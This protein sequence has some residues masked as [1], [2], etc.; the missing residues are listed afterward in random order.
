M[1]LFTSDFECNTL[2]TA[3]PFSQ[4]RK[5]V[6][7]AHKTDDQPT[8]TTYAES[9][10]TL[11]QN[12]Q[13]YALCIFFNAKFD[14]HWYN[15]CGFTLPKR[16]WCCQLAHYFLTGQS[17]RFPSL[18]EVAYYYGYKPKIDVVSQDYWKRGIDTEAIPRTILSEYAERDVDITYAVYLRQQADFVSQPRL[19]RLFELA[20]QDLLLLREMECN[21]LH[22]DA[23][24]CRERAQE[25][26]QKALEHT[27]ILKQVYPHLD[28]NFNSSQQ[29]SAFLYGGVIKSEGREL[30]GFYKTG[31]NKGAPKYKK[32][33]LEQTLPRMAKPLPRSE[34]ATEGIFATDEATLKKLKGPFARKYV[35]H[36]LELARLDK[37]INTYYKGLPSINETMLWE[38]G[39]IHGQLNQVVTATG[40]LSASKPNQQNFAT[41]IQDVFISRYDT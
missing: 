15:E 12:L 18:N 36:L 40:R 14:L 25:C 20:C 30:A 17:V 27:Q 23:D 5:A 32:T 2:N 1:R 19:R 34:M 9:F 3:N 22:F 37:L 28:I 41:E 26:T 31:L 29:L 11:E 4:G 33:L 39:V 10:S 38:P 13:A 24:L 21:G 35:P 6:C 16:V 7:I 8:Q